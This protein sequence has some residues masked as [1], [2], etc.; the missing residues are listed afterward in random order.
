MSLSFRREFRA[1]TL[2][3]RNSYTSYRCF[4]EPIYVLLLNVNFRSDQLAAQQ[5]RQLS[6]RFPLKLLDQLWHINLFP[7]S[8]LSR[9][10]MSVSRISTERTSDDIDHRSCSSFT[11]HSHTQSLDYRAEPKSGDL[12]VRGG[13]FSRADSLLGARRRSSSENVGKVQD[14]GLRQTRHIQGNVFFYLL[15]SSMKKFPTNK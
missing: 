3:I 1:D 13:S 5:L 4:F 14:G 8:R 7:W 15:S 2:F 9:A 6:E 10:E 12:G 11:F